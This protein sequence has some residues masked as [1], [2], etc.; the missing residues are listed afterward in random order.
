QR[1]MTLEPI[2]SPRD[3]SN[4]KPKQQAAERDDDGAAHQIAAQGGARNNV[5]ETSSGGREGG[6][7]G[8]SSLDHAFISAIDRELCAG[9]LC[10]YR[11]A[12]LGC[13]FCH[14]PTR[15]L[16]LEDVVGFVCFYRQTIVFRTGFQDF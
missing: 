10:K 7:G 1:E 3:H 6:H 5:V 2:G 14:I 12:Y 4:L 16:D 9:H 13:E 11:P 8:C 15:D